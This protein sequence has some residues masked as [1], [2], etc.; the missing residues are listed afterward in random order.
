VDGAKAEI[1]GFGMLHVALMPA[2]PVQSS[3]LTLTL[4][5][6]VPPCELLGHLL[7]FTIQSTIY[8]MSDADTRPDDIHPITTPATVGTDDGNEGYLYRL[9]PFHGHK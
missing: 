2:T 5:T 9:G 8:C 1:F 4:S 7:L 3:E 6:L